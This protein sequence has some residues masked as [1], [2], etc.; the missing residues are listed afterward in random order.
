MADLIQ[1][2]VLKW[3]YRFP[4]DRWWREKHKVAF[5][6]PEHRNSS[7]WDQM[8]EYREDVMYVNI[9]RQ[10]QKEYQPN[11]GDWLDIKEKELTSI[12]DN[13]SDALEEMR[14]FKAGQ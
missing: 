13:I 11:E 6:S 14:K 12:E 4:V 5:N 3:N 9:E 7:F 2:F 8:F 1:D 10:D